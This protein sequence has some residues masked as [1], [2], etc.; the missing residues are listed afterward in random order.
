MPHIVIE[1]F[2]SWQGKFGW[3][4]NVDV[5]RIVPHCLIWCIWSERNAR[6]FE[7]CEHSLLEINYFFLHTMIGVWS[8]LIFLVLSFLFFLIIVILVPV[9]CP[10]STSPM[11]SVWHFFLIINNI[12]TLPIK[13]K[14]LCDVKHIIIFIS[15]FKLS[16]VCCWL[17]TWSDNN[18]D[19]R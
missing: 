9:L 8:F 7:G 6:N 13:K 15:G 2:E 18:I 5:W 14:K 4:R 1:L 17:A 12:F 11:Y 16:R 10:Q 3:H 19:L